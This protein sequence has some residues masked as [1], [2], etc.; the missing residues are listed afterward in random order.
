FK[1][2]APNS[3]WWL[4]G[5]LGVLAGFTILSYYSVV[6]GWAL[7]Y[8]YKTAVGILSPG[9]DFAGLFVG[10]ITSQWE[11]IWWLFVFMAITTGVV[12]AGVVKGIQR[13]VQVMMPLLFMLML[14]LIGRGIT[15]PGAGEGLAFHLQPDFSNVS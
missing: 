11:P 13:S 6:G 9:S 15:L 3:P 10:H 8:I 1:A 12:A 14:V 5:A 2:L 7:A 4:V